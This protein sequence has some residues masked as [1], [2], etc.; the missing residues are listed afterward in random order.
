MSEENAESEGFELISSVLQLNT[1]AFLPQS[2]CLL[3]PGIEL[4]DDKE[5]NEL[6]P[7]MRTPTDSNINTV[8]QRTPT[9][10]WESSKSKQTLL[11]LGNESTLMTIDNQ[12]ETL[13]KATNSSSLGYITMILNS[14]LVN[15]EDN[16][17]QHQ[18]WALQQ[19]CQ[20]IALAL[21]I[22]REI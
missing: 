7:V 5:E 21:Q 17:S 13:K 6:Q 22:A 1:L 10:F 20:Y 4:A 2:H 15:V 14:H 18:I 11:P 8:H 19:K 12:I 16:I 3:P 9:T